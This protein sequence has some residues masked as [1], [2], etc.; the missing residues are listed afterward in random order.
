[1][2]ATESV[3]AT[4]HRAPPRGGG[5]V[6]ESFFRSRS[7]RT[8]RR[9]RSVRRFRRAAGRGTL[10]EGYS[11]SSGRP[12]RNGPPQRVQETVEYLTQLPQRRW[13]SDEADVFTAM[14]VSAGPMN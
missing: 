7:G 3:G 11:S 5:A 9:V 10:G 6:P 8:Q 2:W 12:Q 14:N 13:A 4:A 1:M